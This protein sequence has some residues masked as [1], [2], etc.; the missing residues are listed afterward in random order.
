[1]NR[2]GFTL[3]EVLVALVVTVAAL[4]IIAQGLTTG[5]RASVISQNATRAAMLA[6]QVVAGLETGEIAMG[7]SASEAFEDEPDFSYETLSTADPDN[8]GLNYVTITVK[9]TER[10]QDRTYVLTRLMK[11][12]P[13]STN[14]SNP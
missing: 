8:P 3:I 12:R 7:S 5:A 2:A 14:T 9:W 11:D 1:M 6:Q 13:S 10:E 4:G